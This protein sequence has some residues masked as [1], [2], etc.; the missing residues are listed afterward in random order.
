M[1]C[2]KF[3]PRP[4]NTTTGQHENKRDLAARIAKRL[5]YVK[6]SNDPVDRAEAIATEIKLRAAVDDLTQGKCCTEQLVIMSREIGLTMVMCH[7][8]FAQSAE[9]EPLAIAA[10]DALHAV[11]QRYVRTGKWGVSGLELR[12]LRDV[13]D[14]RAELL[15]HE[16]NT[17]GI[18]SQFCVHLAAEIDKGNVI[19]F[20]EVRD[21]VA[22]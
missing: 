8:N 10:R 9:Y 6:E 7:S 1:A 12:A 21:E 14:L 15:A 11:G 2:P 16:E 20:T 13:I 5:A 3:K 4:K 17:K 18:E 19:R 22:A